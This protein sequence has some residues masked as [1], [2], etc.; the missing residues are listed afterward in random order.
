[1]LSLIECLCCVTNDMHQVLPLTDT[2]QLVL[3]LCTQQT[4]C[5][6]I[7]E[8]M[9]IKEVFTTT[10]I[11]WRTLSICSAPASAFV[12]VTLSWKIGNRQRCFKN[13]V[14]SHCS[15]S[16]NPAS[17]AY[18]QEWQPGHKQLL[19]YLHGT[20]AYYTCGHI[21]GLNTC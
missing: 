4:G 3:G 8:H 7:A 16:H 15:V 6:R 5:G 1:M 9:P 12:G 2:Y 21:Q 20:D 17:A 14:F 18:R 11:V 13:A 19:N 10:C